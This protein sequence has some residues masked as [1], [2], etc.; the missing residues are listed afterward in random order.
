MDRGLEAIMKGF[1]GLVKDLIFKKRF[2]GETF[3]I[4]WL[5]SWREF[6]FTYYIVR[7]FFMGTMSLVGER[8]NV[9]HL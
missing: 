6:F 1:D 2:N 7:N 4:E 3:S 9:K 5:P 8:R